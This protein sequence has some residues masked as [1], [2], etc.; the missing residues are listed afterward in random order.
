MFIL[1]ATLQITVHNTG[2]VK[3][4]ESNWEVMYMAICAVESEFNPAAYNRNSGA[5]GIIQI[6]P[7]YV[8]DVNEIQGTNY[9]LE[10]RYNPVKCREMFEIYQSQYNPNKD[11]ATAINLHL[12]G[13]NYS[14]TRFQWYYK[15]VV[16]VMKVLNNNYG[17]NNLERPERL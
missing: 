13:C 12:Q 9:T 2:V 14:T 10:D 8:K 1:L 6:R 7:I 5:A 3:V 4:V 16:E 17:R 15:R 11:I